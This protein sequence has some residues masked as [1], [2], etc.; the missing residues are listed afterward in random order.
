[1]ENK[2]GALRRNLL[3]PPMQL[4]Y[5]L[6][7]FNKDVMIPRSFAFRADEQHYEKGASFRELFVQDR[8]ALGP[9]PAKAFHVAKIESLGTNGTGSLTLESGH[10][11]VL[12]S[13]RT[14]ESVLVSKGAWDISVYTTDGVFIKT[15]PRAYGKEPSTVY[16]IEAK[17]VF[18]F[19][20]VLYNFWYREVEDAILAKPAVTDYLG[21]VATELSRQFSNVLTLNFDCLL[22]NKHM[23]SLLKVQHLHGRFIEGL[24]N[25]GEVQ[26]FSSN[27]G[28]S[29]QYTYLYG[30]NAI[31]KGDRLKKIHD[32]FQSSPPKYYDLDFLF[33]DGKDWGNL[34]V[35]GVS[36]LPTAV[37]PEGFF[38]CFPEDKGVP[39]E[40]DYYFVNSLDGH[41][42]FQIQK[43]LELGMI[44]HVTIACY[45]EDNR[46]LYEEL[47][48]QTP[49]AKNL[50]LCP[51][52]DVP[53]SPGLKRLIGT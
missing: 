20:Y 16:D 44:K 24:Q 43:L 13:G 41:I 31:E 5:P 8:K 49:I 48:S 35:Y 29:F 51:C 37:F 6:Q 38:R 34:L 22:D 7:Q 50:T 2:V 52:K 40:P 25:Y 32:Y 23:P 28:K 53:F 36:F 27:D 39:G 19:L 9:L 26:F 45:S 3:V 1:M 46:K 18:E 12:G 30:S 21:K 10:T 15:F 11:Y 42:L 4:S 47:L 33:G 17:G 14:N